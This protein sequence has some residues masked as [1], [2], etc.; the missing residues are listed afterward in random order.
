MEEKNLE[1]LE[2][3]V[4]TDWFKSRKNRRKNLQLNKDGNS[5][6]G[7]SAWLVSMVVACIILGLM[8][9][10]LFK[11]YKKEG[12]TNTL[13]GSR[14]DMAEMVKYLQTERLKLQTDLANVRETLEEYEETASRGKDET[15]AII[16]RLGRA[17]QEAGLT[18][19]QGPG[20]IVQLNDSPL[21]PKPGDDPNYY[22][23]H[24]IDLLALVNELWASG[25][26]AISINGERI[27]MTTAIRCVGPTITI[28]A[29]RL[30]PPYII[31]AIG[32]PQ[33]LDTGL[34]YTGGFMD[35]M[36]PNLQRGV[37]IRITRENDI[38]IPPFRGSLANRLATVY[39]PDKEEEKDK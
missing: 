31:K 10:L 2:I 24:D 6:G 23:V 13:Y 30:S 4:D 9:S 19:L 21:K 12:T 34:R 1:S 33:N 7:S 14:K 22:I 35:S 5:S 8:V 32:P 37:D 18:G 26:E 15:S 11:T 20:I 16:R 25:A 3:E 39:N 38:K 29:V 27:V 36:T 28:N 17:R